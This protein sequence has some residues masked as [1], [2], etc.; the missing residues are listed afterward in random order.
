MG[1]KVKELTECP[2]TDED[3]HQ[4][5]LPLKRDTKCPRPEMAKSQKSADLRLLVTATMSHF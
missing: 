5:T 2:T 4:E 3:V 1:G